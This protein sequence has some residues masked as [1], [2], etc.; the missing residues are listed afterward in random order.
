MPPDKD[1]V[2]VASAPPQDK[3]Q[4]SCW[5][6][7]GR[8]MLGVPREGCWWLRTFLHPTS[9]QGFTPPLPM[10]PAGQRSTVGSVLYVRVHARH[11]VVL[12]VHT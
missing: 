1:L 5:G 6:P 11:F 4:S 9:V 3:S 12:Y 10:G 8:V 2:S 7:A